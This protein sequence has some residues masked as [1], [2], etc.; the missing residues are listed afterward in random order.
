LAAKLGRQHRGDRRRQRGL[1]VVNVANRA[2]IDV[3]FGARKLFF[4]HFQFSKE[5]Y[6]WIGLMFAVR[7][8]IPC[9]GQ[10]GVRNRR[11]LNQLRTEQKLLRNFLVCPAND[12]IRWGQSTSLREWSDPNHIILPSP[13]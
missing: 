8:G 13:P 12:L 10:L 2:H 1:A 9:H 5:Q 11:Q 6:P 3:G 7:H 4:S